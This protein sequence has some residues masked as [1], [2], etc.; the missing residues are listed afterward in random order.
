[1][2]TANDGCGTDVGMST[3]RQANVDPGAW[4]SCNS[5]ET[6]SDVSTGGHRAGECGSANYGH[7][8]ELNGVGLAGSTAN[9]VPDAQVKAPKG[10]SVREQMERKEDEKLAREDGYSYGEWIARSST[11]FLADKNSCIREVVTLESFMADFAEKE[12]ELLLSLL[13][14]CDQE[15]IK[16]RMDPFNKEVF[17]YH[18]AHYHSLLRKG[19][20]ERDANTHWVPTRGRTDDSKLRRERALRQLAGHMAPET[21]LAVQEGKLTAPDALLG[22]EMEEGR[23]KTGQ[24]RKNGTSVKE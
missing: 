1:M 15:A 10:T 21:L 8:L 12:K 18:V 3:T 16:G 19:L 2:E 6:E 5:L 4:H 9:I 20:L 22:F 17:K 23:K 13:P 24:A 11:S 14:M 7:G